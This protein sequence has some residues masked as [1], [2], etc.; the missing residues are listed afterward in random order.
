MIE[1]KDVKYDPTERVEVCAGR[2][3][4]LIECEELGM[5]FYKLL[6]AIILQRYVENYACFG[7]GGGFTCEEL[8]ELMHIELPKTAHIGMDEYLKIKKEVQTGGARNG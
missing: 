7:N 5:N 1:I 2:L 3:K 4:E 6:K 8:A